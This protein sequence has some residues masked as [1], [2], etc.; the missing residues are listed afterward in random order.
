MGQ[1]FDITDRK[2]DAVLSSE[3]SRNVDCGERHVKG[4]G[5]G[6]AIPC[7]AIAQASILLCVTEAVM[8]SYM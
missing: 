5:Q 1:H 2:M 6:V 7:L 3:L 8:R 4:E